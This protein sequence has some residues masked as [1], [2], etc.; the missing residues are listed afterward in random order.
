MNILI[1]GGAGFVGSNLAVNIKENHSDIC[2]LALD[3]LKRRGSEINLLRLKE[4]GIKFLHGDIRR[5]EDLLFDRAIDLI[6]DAS[7]EPSVLSGL[8]ASPLPVIS[9]NLIGTINLLET[10]RKYNSKL[11]F[12]STSRVY[13]IQELNQINLTE[14]STRF[15]LAEDQ[16]LRGVS[17]FGINE[18][19]STINYRSFYGATKLASEI[20]I[21]EYAQY[22]GLKA[23]INRCGVI[24]GPGQMGKIDQG[25]AVLWMARHYWKNSLKYIGFGGSGK[26]VR[27]MLHIDDLYELVK[28]QISGFS[29]F[30]GKVFNVGGGL[31]SCVSLQELTVICEEITG[32]EIEIGSDTTTREADI[33]YYVS[34][35][36]KI[37][38]LCEWQPTKTPKHIMTDIYEWIKSNEQQLKPILDQ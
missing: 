13:S 26:Q 18:D 2:V 22:C 23:I 11:I 27:D 16:P 20:L 8:N 17:K 34:D 21:Q 30:N 36:A 32:N 25:V 19:F 24:A 5:K 28:K 6:L 29:T 14:N 7:A 3:N 10:A 4:H 12:L 15:E 33:K 37:T 35:N 31:S 38:T 9:N 1:T